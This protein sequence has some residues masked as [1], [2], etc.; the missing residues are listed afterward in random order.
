M[1]LFTIGFTKKNAERFFTLLIDAGVKVIWDTRLNTTSQLAGFAKAE[2]LRFFL[3]KV[4]SV[5]YRYVPE[6]APTRDMLDAYRKREMTWDTYQEQYR[7]LLLERNVAH[8]F[9]ASELSDAC[10][11]CSEDQPTRCHRR[12]AAEYFQQLVPE[13]AV[14]HLI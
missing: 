7:K 11:L 14:T 6:L 5:A 10:L 2:D 4:A 13:L 9:Q 8:L 3:S 1:R 12:L